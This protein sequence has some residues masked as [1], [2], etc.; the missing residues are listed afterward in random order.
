MKKKL[1]NPIFLAAL[2]VGILCVLFITRELKKMEAE[3]Q[4][5]VQQERLEKEKA[6]QEALEA[7]KKIDEF[8][9]LKK[10]GV[11]LSKRLEKLSALKLRFNLVL[12]S[13]E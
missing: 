8:E 12:K 1:V 11:F 13:I 4:A 5:K 3:K 9:R 10:L 7:Q 2:A 6:Q